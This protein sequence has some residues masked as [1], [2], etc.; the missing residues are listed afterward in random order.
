MCPFQ[1]IDAADA[2][3]AKARVAQRSHKKSSRQ[4]RQ[5]KFD[6]PACSYCTYP[7]VDIL[8]LLR[9][10]YVNLINRGHC[11]QVYF[12]QKMRF[13]AKLSGTNE[14]DCSVSHTVFENVRLID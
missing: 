10:L 6:I 1:K 2:P 12:Q 13:S 14:N 7:A 11:S 9:W 5:L 3:A 8:L 4:L